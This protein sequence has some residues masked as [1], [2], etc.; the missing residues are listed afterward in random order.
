MVELRSISKLSFF[1]FYLDCLLFLIM[2]YFFTLSSYFFS[3]ILLYSSMSAST[4]YWLLLQATPIDTRHSYISGR[5][6][7]EASTSFYPRYSIA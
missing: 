5:N 6:R 1:S 2:A 7:H 3:A 4:M